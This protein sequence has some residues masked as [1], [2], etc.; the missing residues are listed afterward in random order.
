MDESIADDVLR[1][2]QKKRVSYGEVRLIN[3]TSN[4]LMM[5]NGSIQIGGFDNSI[6]VGFRFVIDGC[7]GF[8]STNIL[9]KSNIKKSVDS[10]IRAAKKNKKFSAKSGFS[11]EKSHKANYKIFEKTPLAGVTTKDRVSVLRRIEDSIVASKISVPGRFL[12]LSDSQTEKLFLNT[13]GSRIKSSVPKVNFYY[14][15]TVA[16]KSQS[17]QRYWQY[18]ASSG[19]EFFDKMNLSGKLK[20]DVVSMD[21]TLRDGKKCSLSSADFVVGPEVVGI[22]C[23][24]SVGH[25]YE[26]DR[27]LGRESAQ[28]GESFV[29][30]NMIGSKIGS[31]VPTVVD[32]PTISNSFGFYLYDDE[33][34]KA[35]RRFL[36]KDGLINEFLHNRESAFFMNTK[37]N[38]SARSV[39]YNRE[40]IVRMAN[41]F[42]LPGDYSED[43][44]ISETK[45]GIYMKNFTEWNIDDKRFSQKY[46][47]SECWLIKNGR[48][49]DRLKDVF[50]EITT[51]QLWSSVSGIADNTEYHAGTCGKGE[52]MQGIPV[53]FGGPSMKLK[54]LKL[55]KKSV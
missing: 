2:L 41:T 10:A 43:E 26:A 3:S 12:S 46:A 22:M 20:N 7:V 48:L 38:G 37:S 9:E 47:G 5:K 21:K 4:G 11:T 40:P 36:M 54:S 51:P 53:W 39:A 49:T 44:L 23:H 32:D 35:R 13:E 33:G 50:I 25:P 27:I 45:K 14:Y 30:Q 18:G 15:L 42:L 34:I 29:K 24:E 1:L 17:M 6:G 31:N 8:G 55:G 16:S 28:A 52:P 19:Y